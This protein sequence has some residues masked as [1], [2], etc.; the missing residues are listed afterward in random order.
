MKKRRKRRKNERNRVQSH[1]KDYADEKL[2]RYEMVVEMKYI[3]DNET[4]KFDAETLQS[5]KD[6]TLALTYPQAEEDYDFPYRFLQFRLQIAMEDNGMARAPYHFT[7][8]GSEDGVFRLRFIVESSTP[9]PMM[10]WWITPEELNVLENRPNHPIELS[11]PRFNTPHPQLVLW[12][13]PMRMMQDKRGESYGDETKW[14]VLTPLSEADYY[15]LLGTFIRE[16][17]NDARSTLPDNT[18]YVHL[19]SEEW[20]GVMENFPQSY[21]HLLR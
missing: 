1:V 12:L 3:P 10:V 14:D 20:L 2:T 16:I 7:T 18:R 5:L 8:W 15:L 11:I 17:L 21:H 9:K 13:Y 4:V 6:R 19:S